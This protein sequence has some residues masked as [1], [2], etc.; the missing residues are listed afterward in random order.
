MATDDD[1]DD[2]DG[3]ERKLTVGEY[4]AAFETWVSVARLAP[5]FVTLVDG[6]LAE[7]RATFSS[8][9][10]REPA[11][12]CTV[13]QAHFDAADLEWDRRLKLRMAI[14]KSCLLKRLIYLGEPLRTRPCPLHKGHWAGCFGERCPHGCD[15]G[16]GCTT[17]WLPNDPA[18]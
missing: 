1:R 14:A 4:V 9:E 5:Q 12:Y 16:C 7:L 2:E 18:E 6:G 15:R 3:E 13:M 11:A 17:G 10:A 8:D